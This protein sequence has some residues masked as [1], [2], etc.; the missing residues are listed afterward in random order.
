LDRE[1]GLKKYFYSIKIFFPEPLIFPQMKK[2]SD[3]F[4]VYSSYA[5]RITF[6]EK[7]SSS[8]GDSTSDTYSR[9][10]PDTNSNDRDRDKQYF[11]QFKLPES[12]DKSSLIVCQQDRDGNKSILNSDFDPPTIDGGTFVSVLTKEGQVNGKLLKIQEDG[13][14]VLLTDISEDNPDESITPNPA[15]RKKV[16]R[17]RIVVYKYITMEYLTT[18]EWDFYPSLRIRTKDFNETAGNRL[19][20]SYLMKEISWSGKYTI[21]LNTKENCFNMLRYNVNIENQTGEILQASNTSVLSGDI[22]PPFKNNNSYRQESQA[23]VKRSGVRAVSASNDVGGL[24]YEEEE[25]YTDNV[26]YSL[27]PYVLRSYNAIC[28]FTAIN[29]PYC[30]F[31]VNYLAPKSPVTYLYRIRM[32]DLKEW[33]PESGILPAGTGKILSVGTRSLVGPYLGSFNIEETRSMNDNVDLQFGKT[34]ALTVSTN[35]NTRTEN[36]I[37]ESVVDK[38]IKQNILY[39]TIVSTITNTQDKSEI[40]ILKYNIGSDRIIDLFMKHSAGETIHDV[41]RENS[42]DFYVPVPVPTAASPT[43]TFTLN[44]TSS[45]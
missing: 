37:D 25:S 30:K 44:I 43:I 33:L 26:R 16:Y 8:R 31:Y 17:R 13:S 22:T 15:V 7:N 40:I 29:V 39:T 4:I 35:I 18:D 5:Q 42:I 6:W 10:I 3:N 11:Y 12:V 24:E 32:K 45:Y 14:L 19:I 1:T 23:L 20:I 21:I 2:F 9:T 38:T 28:L 41:H 34:T 36:E 27:G